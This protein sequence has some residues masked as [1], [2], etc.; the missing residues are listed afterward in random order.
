MLHFDSK[1]IAFITILIALGNILA[2]ISI[3]VAPILGGAALDLSHIAT[4]VAAVY[5]GPLLGG[6]VGLFGGAYSGYAFGWTAGNLGLLSLLGIPFG[7]A[8]TGLTMGVLYRIL[9][10][11]RRSQPSILT[12]PVVLSSYVPECLF[13]IFFFTSIVPFFFGW[14]ATMVLVVIPKAWVEIVFMSF[15]MAALAGNQGF[16]AFVATFLTGYKPKLKTKR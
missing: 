9:K 7:K 1:Q 8:L 10:I 14:G 4:F 13:T 5:G 16:S 6:V 15:L 2:A 3:N 11:N 12:I